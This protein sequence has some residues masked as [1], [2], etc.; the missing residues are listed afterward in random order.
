MNL[1][2]ILVRILVLEL[3]A[4]AAQFGLAFGLFVPWQAWIMRPGL[5]ALIPYQLVFLGAGLVFYFGLRVAFAV[6]ILGIVV[7]FVPMRFRINARLVV[8]GT[9]AAWVVAALGGALVNGL[10]HSPKI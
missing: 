2:L 5:L 1:R 8:I 4:L 10:G 6:L 3:W 7:S 9:V